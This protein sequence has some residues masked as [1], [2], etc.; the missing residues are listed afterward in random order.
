MRIL[1]TGGAGFIGSHTTD[2]LVELGHDVV[3]IDA[4][5]AP[6]HRYG[7]PNYVTPGAELYVGDVRNRELVANLLRRV[8]AVYHLAAYQDY[9]PDF[10]RFTDVNVM[11]TALLY[12]I[13]VAQGLELSRIVVASSQ[14][15][16][17]EGLYLCVEHGEQT[18]DIR[19]EA[20]LRV[21]WKT[22]YLRR[23]LEGK[24]GSSCPF[25]RIPRSDSSDDT[26]R[27]DRASRR[28]LEDRQFH[29]GD[30][31]DG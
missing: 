25:L 29:L 10:A 24:D 7:Q 21:V 31:V 8:D 12:E 26:S 1:V 18:P 11:S 23:L 5:T 19:P 3:V 13:A 27:T 2:R 14:S 22:S 20:V 28:K 9:L 6:V 4:L 17:G 30:T 15:A 16:M